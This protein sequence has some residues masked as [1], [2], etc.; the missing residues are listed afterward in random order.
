MSDK[1]KGYIKKL[2]VELDKDVTDI[3]HTSPSTN[4]ATE[5]IMGLVSSKIAAAAQGY[6]VDIYGE[7]SKKTLNEE[8]FKDP[9]NANKF[10]DLDMRK[11][12]N[13]AYHFDIQ[14]IKAYKDGIDFNEIK[15]VYAAAAAA[16]GSA[17]LSGLLMG[18][19]TGKISIPIVVIIAG[20]LLIGIGG[21]TLTSTKIVPAIN[22]KNYMIAVKKFMAELER[23]LL[24][25]VDGVVKFY[26]QKVDELKATL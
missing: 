20:A 22:K 5:N 7:L 3:V 19:L 15:S 6:M 1:V 26:N 16:V 13:D 4:T 18:G 11:R 10:Y 9:A 21:G 25:W 24:L 14:S 12:I 23:E 17:T 2:F 8:L